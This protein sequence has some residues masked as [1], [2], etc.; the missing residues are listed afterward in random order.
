MQ[1][2]MEMEAGRNMGESWGNKGPEGLKKPAG[3]GWYKSR[4]CM[5]DDYI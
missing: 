5:V 4:I 2:V 3:V 1:R